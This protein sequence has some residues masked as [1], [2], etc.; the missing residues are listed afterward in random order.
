MD[1]W[2]TLLEDLLYTHPSLSPTDVAWAG[3]PVREILTSL[4]RGL[5]FK[6]LVYINAQS[7]IGRLAITYHQQLLKAIQSRDKPALTIL[8]KAGVSREY[9]DNPYLP[10][11]I[12]QQLDE[13]TKEEMAALDL[14]MTQAVTGS[15]PPEAER[16]TALTATSFEPLLHGAA[17]QRCHQEVC[18]TTD[19]KA[20]VPAN[21]WVGCN[22]DTTVTAWCFNLPE[23]LLLLLR[24]QPNPYTGRP[25]PRVAMATLYTQYPTELL[26]LTRSLD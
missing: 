9:D 22:E 16:P 21:V 3:P 2:A 13:Q 24:E 10:K 11:D 23:L 7:P 8:L 14:L 17:H 20:G 1:P 12:K 4:E 19:S 5:V 25:F 26:V 15:V 6:N 18:L